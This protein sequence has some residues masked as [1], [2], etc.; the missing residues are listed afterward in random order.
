MR[1]HA[2]LMLAT[3]LACGHPEKP[4]EPLVGNSTP[5]TASA[6]VTTTTTTDP[7]GSFTTRTRPAATTSGTGGVSGV[8]TNTMGEPL[9][10]VTI[11]VE[12][13][14]LTGERVHISDE[15]GEFAIDQFPAG[16]YEITLYYNNQTVRRTFTIEVDRVTELV[17]AKWN[18]A[19]VPPA[20]PKP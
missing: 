12:G 10:G 5:P 8:I 11:V 17:L 16:T 15:N 1:I 13:T 18:E 3:M 7:L 20:D 19:F 2:L 4:R 6:P 14:K 9:V